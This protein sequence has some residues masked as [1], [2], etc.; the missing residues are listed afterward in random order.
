[1]GKVTDHFKSK[2]VE[3]TPAYQPSKAEALNMPVPPPSS[4]ERAGAEVVG[5]LLANRTQAQS[6]WL[7]NYQRERAEYRAAVE[8]HIWKKVLARNG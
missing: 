3:P 6:D 7:E 8:E 2:A 4:E 5:R 1:M